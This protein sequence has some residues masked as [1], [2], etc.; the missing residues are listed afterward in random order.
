MSIANTFSSML[1]L[2]GTYKKTSLYLLL[3]SRALNSVIHSVLGHIVVN[4][5]TMLLFFFLNMIKSISDCITGT[6][7]LII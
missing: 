5:F 3:I 1:I 2:Y 4:L 7:P 6:V